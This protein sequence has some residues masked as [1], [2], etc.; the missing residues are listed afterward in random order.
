MPEGEFR[1]TAQTL[2][3]LEEVLRVELVQLGAREV[4]RHNRAVSFRGDLG[5][6]YK[7]NLCLRTALRILVP[8]ETFS[9]RSNEEL[10]LGIK[11]MPWEEYMDVDDT[12]SI[13]VTLNTPFF[14]HSQFTAQKA[15]DAIADRF[16]ERTGKR[17]SVDREQPTVRIHLHIAQ[18]NCMVSLDSTGG[19]LHQ[20]G[21]RDQTNLAPI[22]EVLA[23]GM[24]LLTG[25][26]KESPLVDPMC[27][28]GTI[29]IEAAL[30]AAN[31]PP[32]YYRQG[33]GF[34]RWRDFDEELWN[35]IYTGAIGRINSKKPVILGGEISPNV[36]R[37]AIANIHEAKL[38]DTI[39]IKNCAFADLEPP[40]IVGHRPIGKPILIMNPPYGERMDKDEDINALYKSI[41]DTLKKRWAGYDAWIITSNL[42]AAKHIKLTPRPKIQLFNG[43]LDCRFMRYELYSGSRR[44]DVPSDGPEETATDSI[45]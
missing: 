17:P 23:A 4:Q 20:R 11:G 24:V 36:A 29:L 15:K 14:T 1:M 10:Y 5:T 21:Y 16:R 43:A 8:I 27:G 39:T 22:N 2:H 3:G 28:S 44:R 13:I 31:I 32:G 45:S 34:Q 7:A 18:E 19:S 25:W 26:D 41:G 6:M 30:I 35:T 38:E 40:A 42:A 9:A 12:L 33:F 37:K